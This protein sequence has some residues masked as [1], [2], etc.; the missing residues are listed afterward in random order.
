MEEKG[1]GI[2][3]QCIVNG[4]RVGSGGWGWVVMGRRREVT[5]SSPPACRDNL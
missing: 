3:L 1:E 2:G 5:A 4:I